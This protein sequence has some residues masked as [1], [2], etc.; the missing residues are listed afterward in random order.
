MISHQRQA[1]P[2]ATSLSS[3]NDCS[4]SGV[5]RRKIRSI[6]ASKPARTR[7]RTSSPIRSR[8]GAPPPTGTTYRPE[9]S[10]WRE[11]SSTLSVNP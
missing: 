11:A 9:P 10:W 4:P 7:S 2:G 3:V 1:R 8:S 6:G 5:V